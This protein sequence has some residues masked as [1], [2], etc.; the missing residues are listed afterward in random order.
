MQALLPP[1]VPQVAVELV[2]VVPGAARALQPL[3]GLDKA[4]AAQ[5]LLPQVAV[6]LVTAVPGAA[7]ALPLS[8]AVAH[9]APGDKA[10]AASML[11]RAS[12]DRSACLWAGRRN[13][14]ASLLT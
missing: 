3:A 10:E 14:P 6:E 13:P 4:V 11:R 2:R 12:S 5:A 9:V 1:S 7:R 8:V